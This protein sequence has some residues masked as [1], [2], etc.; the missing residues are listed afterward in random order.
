MYR[1]LEDTAFGPEDIEV[2]IAPFRPALES[3]RIVDDTS[4]IAR[5][6]AKNIVDVVRRGERDPIL[7]HER[8]LGP[9]MAFGAT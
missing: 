1:Y 3:L 5:L 7:L 4:P 2:I 8:A 6:V 9:A